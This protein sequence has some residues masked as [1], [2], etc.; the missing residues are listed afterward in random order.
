[1]RKAEI[2][3]WEHQRGQ[4]VP[5]KECLAFKGLRQISRDFLLRAATHTRP[6]VGSSVSAFELLS[7]FHRWPHFRE[8]ESCETKRGSRRPA[9][10]YLLQTVSETRK[11]VAGASPKLPSRKALW[12]RGLGGVCRRGPHS[13]SFSPAKAGP[14]GPSM[15]GERPLRCCPTWQRAWRPFPFCDRRDG[16]TNVASPAL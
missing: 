2:G 3:R 14:P 16:K 7:P 5:S 15:P 13:F 11:L 1:V 4:S 9:G 12:A 6:Q 10:S 8:R